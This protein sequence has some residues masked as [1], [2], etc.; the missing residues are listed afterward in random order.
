MI[1]KGIKIHDYYTGLCNQLIMFIH[2]VIECICDPMDL[3]DVI[4]VDD[5]KTDLYTNTYSPIEEVFDMD[6]ICSYLYANFG[7]IVVGKHQLDIEI[8]KAVYGTM[9]TFI[10]VQDVLVKNFIHDNHFIFPRYISLNSLKGDPV[11]NNKKSLRITYT[12]KDGLEITKYYTEEFID[13][14]CHFEDIEYKQYADWPRQLK[15]METFL[16]H[17]SF[18]PKFYTKKNIYNPLVHVIHVRLEYDAIKHWANENKMDNEA[19]YNTLAEKYIQAI[20]Q[21]VQNGVIMVL[22]YNSDNRVVDW[23]KETGREYFFIEKDKSQGREWNAIRDIVAAET[24][25]NG[26]FI[27]NFDI[28]RMQGST[29]SYF[30]MKKCKNFQKHV[31]VDIE[32]IHEEPFVITNHHNLNK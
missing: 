13:I 32:R 31:L 26:V 4:V 12:I 3:V 27:G 21:H 6:K 28:Y 5:F 11:L 14:N 24:Y 22:S 18:H 8:K 7:V 19:F 2:G 17:F 23:L 9:T 25:G 29:F 10:D 1:I 30:L 16:R 20:E 15:W